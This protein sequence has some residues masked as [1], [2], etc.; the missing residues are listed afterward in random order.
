[1]IAYVAKDLTTGVTLAAHEHAQLP[2]WSTIKILLAVAFWR[3]VEHGE[4]SQTEVFAFQPG[5]AVG[6]CGVLRGFRHPAELTLADYCHLSLAV[7]DNDA[8]NILL[9]FVGL[10]RVNALAAELGLAESRM[11][12]RMMDLEAIAEGR[13][14]LTSAADLAALLEE[15]AAGRALS[16]AVREPVLASLAGQEHLDGIPR[17]LPKGAAYAGKCGDDAPELRYAHD[18]G[19]VSEGD[20]R[21]VLVILT[22]GAGGY[23]PVSRLAAALYGAVRSA[24]PA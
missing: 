14:N 1:V 3:A 18:C 4:L 12:R 6:G 21:V 13:Q 23:E 10:D 20:G 7:S 16:A 5:A 2:A 9:G 24:T 11:Q 17:Y 19:L 22:D 8:T 15:L